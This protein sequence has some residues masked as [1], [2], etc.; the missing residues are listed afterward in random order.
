MRRRGLDN[1]AE[2]GGSTGSDSEEH[3]TVAVN[4]QQAMNA[5]ELVE[6]RKLRRKKKCKITRPND[7]LVVGA[8]MIYKRKIKD[9]EVEKYK[10][11]LVT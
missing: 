5:L 4:G 9:S 8:R 2:E 7:K 3:V 6:W 10:C 1:F 11:R